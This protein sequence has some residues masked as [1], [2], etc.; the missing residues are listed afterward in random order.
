MQKMITAI[1]VGILITFG[2]FVFMAYL[3]SQDKNV[4]IE[5]INYPVVD[6]YQTPKDTKV[7]VKVKPVLTPPPPMKVPKIE[8]IPTEPITNDFPTI[9]E[10]EMPAIEV[11]KSN[12]L[13]GVPDGEARPIMRVDPK[14]PIKAAKNGVEGWVRLSFS[15][16]KLGQVFNISIIESNPKRIFDKAAKRALKKWKYRAKTVNGETVVQNQLSVQLDFNMNQKS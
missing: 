8:L 12:I 6:V 15:I 11:V 7:V 3:V 2:L 16:D 14:Y 10:V 5:P 9:G 4:I 1:L 13:G